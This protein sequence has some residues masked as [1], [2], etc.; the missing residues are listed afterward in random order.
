MRHL[1]PQPSTSAIPCVTY[2]LRCP[3]H[4]FYFRSRAQK[5]PDPRLLKL[6]EKLAF[7]TLDLV[8]YAVLLHL[9]VGCWVF[10]A[11]R[12]TGGG[13]LFPRPPLNSVLEN[14]TAVLLDA[15]WGCSTLEP[16]SECESVE[17]CSWSNWVGAGAT[18]SCF[19][20]TTDT[21]YGDFT[22]A[23]L[24]SRLVNAVTFPYVVVTAVVCAFELFTWTPVYALLVVLA[25]K[26]YADLKLRMHKGKVGLEREGDHH[27]CSYAMSVQTNRFGSFPKDYDLSR[28]GRYEEVLSLGDN[29]EVFR[30][31]N[32]H[33]P[34]GVQNARAFADRQK[35]FQQMAK[36]GSQGKS[37][38]VNSKKIFQGLRGS[39]RAS[40]KDMRLQ[41]G[42]FAELNDDEP[43]NEVE[44][45]RRR[46]VIK[47]NIQAKFGSVNAGQVTDAL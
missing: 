32:V 22:A 9:L 21:S 19:V 24:S 38:I 36:Q 10:S 12:S 23:E 47:Q 44:A 42:E 34:L 4:F 13:H 11:A 29:R 40:Q 20:N 33:V 41:I 2:T 18:E 16:A 37:D 28:I 31:I 8:K 46:S 3:R 30:K 45:Q 43:L 6:P 27:I 26:G 35:Q 17:G 39:F 14:Y 25:K 7:W 1:Y 15:S 5:T